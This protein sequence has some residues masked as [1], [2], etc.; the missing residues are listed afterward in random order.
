MLKKM[1]RVGI[2]IF[3]FTVLSAA[4][5]AQGVSGTINCWLQWGENPVREGSLEICRIG[6]PVEEGYCLLPEFGSGIVAGEEIP[7]EAFALWISQKA[8]G[9]REQEP[10]RNGLVRF[11]DLEPGIYLVRQSRESESYYP[12]SPYLACVSPELS[13]IDTFPVI[14]LK[15]D[16]PR[17]GQYE[18]VYLGSLGI[19]V[20]LTGIFSCFYL[21][22]EKKSH[23]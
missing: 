12:I 3:M 9:G 11:D 8:A 22:S 23:T 6:D 1:L 19:A 13:L 17:T 2:F 5:Q 21:K 4:V 10:D 18:E 15:G 7:S 14:T 20:T 16:L